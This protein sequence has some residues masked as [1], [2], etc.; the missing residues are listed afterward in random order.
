MEQTK[1]KNVAA[2]V[3]DHISSCMGPVIPVLIAGGLVKLVVIIFTAAGILAEGSTTEQILSLIGD[4]PL[5]FLPFFLAYTASSHFH[6][7]TILAIG[8][9]GA[10]MSPSFVELASSQEALFFAGIPVI[11]ATYAYS[12]IPV[13]LLIAVMVYIEKLVHKIMPKALDDI[14][15]PLVILLL[16]ALAG[17]LAI[18]PL[19]TLI[20]NLLSGGMVWLQAH[21]PVA[22]WAL[23][24][25]LSP[26]MV[27]TGIHWVFVAIAVGQLGAYGM[28]DG[29]MAG[30]FILTLCQA[31]ASF[32]VFLKAKTPALKKLAL[33]CGIT[34]FLTGV[35]EPP[36]YG[37]TLKYKRPFITSMIGAAIAGAYQGLVTI[38]CYVYAFP[39]VPSFLMFSSKEEPGN[40]LKA[41]IAAAISFAVSFL[42][43]YLFAGP[44]DTEEQ[45]ASQSQ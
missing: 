12:T 24:A 3:I 17:L 18:G 5:Y 16:S 35:T 37:V 44:L 43:T 23:F 36:I 32:A 45:A 39:G 14:L 33:S 11:K 29:V 27:I 13:I 20:G 30:F 25:G 34:V 28:E 2:I 9:V 38:H 8:A 26:L 15:S 6:V 40:L 19:G 21:A 31:G 41:M 7:N 42:L 10:M 22:A 1:K 4:S